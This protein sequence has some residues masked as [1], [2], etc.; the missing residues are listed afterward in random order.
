MSAFICSHTHI[1]AMLT[2]LPHDDQANLLRRIESRTKTTS[3]WTLTDVGRLLLDE[4]E[5]SVAS[6]YPNVPDAE[7]P[8]TIGERSAGYRFTERPTSFVEGLKLLD[9]W[10]YQSCE[11]DDH[12]TTLAWQVSMLM[13]DALIGALP[14]YTEAAW[15]L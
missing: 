15:S 11:T 9:S 8:G 6:R 1:D 5:R 3:A 12:A 13:T 7:R 14:G 2:A 4:N 10:R